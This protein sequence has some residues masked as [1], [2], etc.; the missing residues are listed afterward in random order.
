M[1]QY[2]QSQQ[3]IKLDVAGSSTFGRDPKILAS[4]TFNMILADGWL[5]D[6]FGY[7]KAVNNVGSVEGRGIFSSVRSNILL[8]VVDNKVLVTIV[9]GTDMMGNKTYSTNEIGTIGTFSGNVY[10]DENNVDQIAICDQQNIYIYN[11]V[12]STFQTAVLPVGVLPGYIAYQNTRFIF[13]DKNSA[14]WY[15]S[16]TGDG[17]NW[18]P[19][20]PGNSLFSAI[21]TKPDLAQATLRVPGRGNLLYV[22]GLTVTEPWT[23]VGGPIFPYQKSSS[24][25]IDYGCVNASTIASSDD[26]VAW[27]GS[28]EKSGPT[29]M[30]A[31]ASGVQQISTDG[32]NFK[33]S[34]LEN[35]QA[36][37]G[38]FVKLAG[39]LCYQLTFYDPKDNFSI[40]Y[41]FTTQQFFDVTDED[42]NYH[43]ARH[44][45]F[46]DNDYYFISL[47]DGNIYQMSADFTTFD[48]GFYSDGVT[49]KVFEI[50]RVR[51]CSNIR[52][53]N[54]FRFVVNNITFTMEQGNDDLNDGL[55]GYDPRIALAVSANGG[56]SF[57]SYKSLPLNVRGHR[58]N[59]L[60][61]FGMGAANDF[62]AQIRMYGQGPWKASQGLVSIYQ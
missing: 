60:D 34:N 4:R 59:K 14:A 5:Q 29:I 10:I 62:V 45:A 43:I 38:F 33:L 36:S 7:K 44:V 24:V 54:S 16:A 15:V 52:A 31:T 6:Y 48:Y 3:V 1:K 17:L 56:I 39:H 35:P 8:T 51:V 49:P 23:D 11:P 30:Y 55:P 26:V 28:N 19:V 27:L 47:N 53:E 32:I 57:G 61:W 50:P 20:P 37:T 12:L 25:N 58:L 18:F 46:F 41:D 13:P 42:M 9:T 2:S 21:Q 40:M 22:M